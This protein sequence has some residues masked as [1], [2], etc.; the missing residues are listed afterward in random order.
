VCS[1]ITYIIKPATLHCE[2]YNCTG[3]DPNDRSF[4]GRGR[5]W[6]SGCN[7]EVTHMLITMRDDVTGRHIA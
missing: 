1:L 4:R 7:V 3:V 2:A 5:Q 6:R